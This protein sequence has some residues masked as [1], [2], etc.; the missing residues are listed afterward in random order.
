MSVVK[1]EHR[2]K[3]PIE[4][5]WSVISDPDVYARAAPVLSEVEVL[6][7][8]GVGMRRS[9]HD[10][11]GRSWVEYCTEWEEGSKLSMSIDTS[12][13][14][15]PFSEMEYTWALTK[16]PDDDVLIHIEYKYSAGY[17]ALG[18]LLNRFSLRRKV[19]DFC[20]ALMHNWDEE[21]GRREGQ[22]EIT[23]ET[24]LK[25]KGHDVV[26]ILP[27]LSLTETAQL[28]TEKRIGAVLV[29]EGEELAGLV[30]ERDIVR[31]LAKHGKQALEWPV[32]E[33]MTKKLHVCHPESDLDFL[34]SCMTE[35]RVRHLPVL[36]DGKV[37]GLVSIGDVVKARIHKLEYDSES[38]RIYIEGRQWQWEHRHRPVGG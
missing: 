27:S 16:L 20:E 17:G 36:E 26:S 4:V 8:H 33:I 21:I 29:M 7:G 31:G 37:V 28:L 2:V 22:Y 10:K 12:D 35:R 23:V 15:Y 5:V 38:K 25:D 14:P 18:S 30:S 24:I 32:S 6:Y 3:A 1:L 13:F 19:K 9:C 34:M 11:L